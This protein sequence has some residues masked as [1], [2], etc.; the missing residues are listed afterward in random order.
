MLAGM[1]VLIDIIVPVFA[2][3]GVGFTAAH[4]RWLSEAGVDGLGAFVFNFAIPAMLFKAMATRDMPETIEWS[5]LIAYFG[6]AYLSWFVGIAMFRNVF[7][8]DWATASVLGLGGAF[9]NAVMLGLPLVHLAFGEAGLLPAFLIISFH[10]WQLFFVVTVLVETARGRKGRLTALVGDVIK[11]LVSNPIIVAVLAGILWNALDL[12]LAGPVER[13]LDLLGRAGIPCALFCL[14]ASLAR[15]E[16]KGALPQASVIGVLK[17]GL[18]PLL[19]YL[20][21]AHLFGLDGLW[22]S[23]AVLM[24]ATPVGINVYLFGIRYDTGTAP[25][26]TSILLTTL[27]SVATLSGVLWLLG[28]G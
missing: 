13:F 16:L 18:H 25:A 10:T 3:V 20:I 8:R 6:A 23:V 26:A 28:V 2:V 14:G 11:G 12:G 19:V 7:R 17:L 21:G 24:A 5:L 4:K 9:S 27:V 22:L 15:Y 1:G